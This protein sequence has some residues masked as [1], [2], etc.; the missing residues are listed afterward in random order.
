MNVRAELRKPNC[1][2]RAAVGGRAFTLIELLVVISIIALL[3]SILVAALSKAKERSRGLICTYNLKTLSLAWFS[4]VTSNN[5][6]LVGGNTGESEHDWVHHPTGT[7]DSEIERK[8]EGIR[9]GMLFEFVETIDVYH[10]P[11]DKRIKDPSQQ[12]FRSY[13]IAGGM[14]GRHE[15]GAGK[16]V[17][18]YSD[19]K[20]PGSKYVF[21][22][23]NDPR[24][25]NARAWHLDPTGDSWGDPLAVW[26]NKKSTLGFAD[27][28]S[29]LH[30]WR[31]ERTMEFSNG[32]AWGD[33]VA[34]Q[35][36]NPDLKY[37]QAGYAIKNDS[38]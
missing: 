12:T 29:E 9:E 28:H 35:P 7:S 19:I 15:Y 2:T 26:H 17:E 33:D 3:M 21:V 31:D 25:F 27:G 36:D 34:Y 16:S 14:N 10:C 30:T 8:K 24:G 32:G 6:K 4:Y 11:S 38:N 22:E 18:I 5:G 37:M 23:E 13:S 1:R 20:G